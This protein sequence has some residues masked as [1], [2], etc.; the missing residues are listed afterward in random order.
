MT[1]L[2]G[3]EQRRGPVWEN[4]RTRIK[5][6][7]RKKEKGCRRGESKGRGNLMEGGLTRR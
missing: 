4:G 3:G 1:N 6:A 2:G 7:K 5:F